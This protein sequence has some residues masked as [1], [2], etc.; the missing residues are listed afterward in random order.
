MKNRQKD[1]DR[2]NFQITQD[3]VSGDIQKFLIFSVCRSFFC[4]TSKTV[5]RKYYACAKFLIIVSGFAQKFLFPGVRQF[6]CLFFIFIDDFALVSLIYP[7]TDKRIVQKSHP[8]QKKQE[9]NQSLSFHIFLLLYR[10]SPVRKTIRNA[11]PIRIESTYCRIHGLAVCFFL[12][13]LCGFFCSVTRCP[14]TRSRWL[15]MP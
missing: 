3:P 12:A 10:N 9:K 5:T 14:L 7:L 4:A 13:A 11:M 2:R 1:L 15:L 6:L 8:H